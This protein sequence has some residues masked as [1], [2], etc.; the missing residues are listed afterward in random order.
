M[1]NRFIAIGITLMFL[2]TGFSGCVEDKDTNPNKDNSNFDD[3]IESGGNLTE[4]DWDYFVFHHTSGKDLHA[5]FTSGFN[6]IDN[7]LALFDPINST[8]LLE[9][10][11]S[12]QDT[13][14]QLKSI[15]K[16]MNAN[17]SQYRTILQNFT[18][19]DKMINHGLEQ[20][21]LINSYQNLSNDFLS[22]YNKINASFELSNE[23]TTLVD[24]SEEMGIIFV[25]DDSIAV[26]MDN[27]VE[28]IVSISDEE[29]DEWTKDRDWSF[30]D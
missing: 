24:I 6:I 23:S 2:I 22:V 14:F 30:M 10:N 8:F 9:L 17:I 18:L 27:Q 16:V 25:G 5:L 15:S 3:N 7:E 21:K 12:N 11:L 26:I 1:N 13:L 4:E 20:N 19:S 28:I 29:W